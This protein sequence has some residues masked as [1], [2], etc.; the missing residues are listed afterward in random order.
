MEQRFP[1]RQERRRFITVFGRKTVHEALLDRSL[2]A[3]TLHLAESNRSNKLLTELEAIATA[4]DIPI[5]W[6]TRQELARISRNSKQDQGVALDVK[7]PHM[8]ELADFLAANSNRPSLRFIALDG[9]TNPQNLGMVIRSVTASGIDGLLLP[10]HGGPALGP[11]VI[12]ASAGTAFRAP[13]L[14]CQ[15]ILEGAELLLEQNFSLYRLQANGDQATFIAG[16]FADKSLCI[17]GGET[18]GIS[19]PLQALPGIDVAIPMHNDVESLNVAVS[20]S[21]LAYKL[22]TTPG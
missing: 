6:H 7:S 22:A 14:R 3:H 20:A 19:R 10:D 5:R 9:V 16:D 17:L 4:R 15:S 1:S 8:Q 2:S 12:K 11:L 18:N 21:L 13:L